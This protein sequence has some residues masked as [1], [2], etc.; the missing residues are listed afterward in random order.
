MS[1]PLIVAD[2]P[3]GALNIYSNTEHAFGPHDQELAALFAGQ[4]SGIL[5]AAGVEQTVDEVAERLRHAL[6]A[7]EVIAQAQGAIMARQR[8]SADAAY[9]TLR[10]AARRQTVTVQTHAAAIVATASRDDLIGQAG[11]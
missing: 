4:A 2:R 9:A 6:S 3:V 11:T 10:R 7:R 5:A 1:T 8:I